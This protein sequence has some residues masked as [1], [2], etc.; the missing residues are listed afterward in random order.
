MLIA[1]QKRRRT[2]RSICKLSFIKDKKVCILEHGDKSYIVLYCTVNDV[3]SVTSLTL[4]ST[5]QHHI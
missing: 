4:V 2:Y 1:V 3:T 5:Q